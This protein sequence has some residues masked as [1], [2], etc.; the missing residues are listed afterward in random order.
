MSEPE[1]GRARGRRGRRAGIAAASLFAVAIALL[2]T[3]REPIAEQIIRSE[4]EKRGVPAS[5]RLVAIG[6]GA[7]TLRNIRLGP[8]EA[9][10][11]VAGITRVGLRWAWKGHQFA[12][13][14]PSL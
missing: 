12:P 5:Y 14:L 7:A 9:P 10:G 13:S 8:P 3:Q 2:W 1:T 6:P 4:L 11:L